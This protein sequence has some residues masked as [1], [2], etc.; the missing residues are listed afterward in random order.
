MKKYLPLIFLF[1]ISCSKQEHMVEI[2]LL[3]SRAKNKIGISCDEF[4]KIKNSEGLTESNI[5]RFSTI[6]TINKKIIFAG[7]FDIYNSNLEDKPFIEDNEFEYLDLKNNK[8][9]FSESAVEKI[10]SLKASMREGIQFVVTDNKKP[11]FGGYFWNSFSSFGS[12]WNC[13]SFVHDIKERP[14]KEKFNHILYKGN[15]MGFW[16]DN[17]IDLNKYPQ[18]LR[19]LEETQKIKKASH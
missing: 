1:F 8:I 17:H 6:D 11:V 15:G 4:K 13:I 18:F 12:D 16:L 9:K 2:Y 19:A 5:G 10:L 7:E 14:E 3:K